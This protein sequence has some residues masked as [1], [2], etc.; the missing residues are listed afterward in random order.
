MEVLGFPGSDLS[1]PGGGAACFLLSAVG[2]RL[3]PA[4]TRHLQTRDARIGVTRW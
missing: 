1:V 3:A 2:I 4:N